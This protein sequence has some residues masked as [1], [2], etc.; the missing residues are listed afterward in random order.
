[1]RGRMSHM[2]TLEIGWFIYK[3]NYKKLLYRVPLTHFRLLL[4][5]TF[6]LHLHNDLYI[7]IYISMYVCFIIM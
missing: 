2:P 4:I 6:A 5:V 7:S 3:L 1:M